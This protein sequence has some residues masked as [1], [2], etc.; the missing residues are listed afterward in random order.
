[1]EELKAV[2]AYLFQRSGKPVL[3]SLELQLT[4]SHGLRWL[5]PESAQLLVN[6]A[7]SQQLVKRTAD[8]KLT[9]NFDYKAL[10]L[11]ID[12]KFTKD[13]LDMAVLKT[14]KEEASA[15]KDTDLV[16]AIVSCIC[17]KSKL[18]K[19][20]IMAEIN[21]KAK[22]LNIDLEVAGLLVARYHNVDVSQFYKAVEENLLKRK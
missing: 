18:D 3:S 16:P 17:S 1:M 4:L 19:H 13:M 2:I 5:T 22:S 9:P 21:R 20:Q 11:P 10:Q 15:E 6:L 7:I 14:K 8:D 12:F